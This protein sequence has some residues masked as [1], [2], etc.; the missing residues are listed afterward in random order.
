MDRSTS[1]PLAEYVVEDDV[2]LL[3]AFGIGDMVGIEGA[4]ERMVRLSVRSS[5]SCPLDLLA[6]RPDACRTCR[7]LAGETR[8]DGS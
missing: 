6:L 8:T 7:L 3:W 4:G 5:L 1:P 2:A